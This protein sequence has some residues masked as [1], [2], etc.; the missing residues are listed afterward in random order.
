WGDTTRAPSGPDITDGA[1][2]TPADVARV[3][4]ACLAHDPMLR[5]ASARAVMAALPGGDPLQAALAAGET[6]SP[7]M[8]AAAG[9]RGDLGLPI[10]WTCLVATIAGVVLLAWMSASSSVIGLLQ[11]DKSPEVLA[12][13]ARGIVV[14]LGHEAPARD[15]AGLFLYDRAFLTSDTRRATPQHALAQMRPGPLLFVFRQSPA[16]LA[17]TH[18]AR[19]FVTPADVGRVDERDPATIV[20]GMATIVLDR[21]GM[22]SE[23]VA[24]PPRRLDAMP[25]AVAF[26]WSIAF[27]AAGLDIARFT[28]TAPRSTAPV[29]S[30][31]KAAWDGAY[32][33]PV[34]AR[35]HVEAAA[36]RGKPVWFAVQD[37]DA[38][39]PAGATVAA[40]ERFAIWAALA[41]CLAIAPPLILMIVR[42]LRAGRGD[43]RGAG[44]LA[45]FTFASIALA[46]L[47]RAD[48]VG[49][50]D[51][52][53]ALIVHILAQA[54]YFAGSIWFAYIAFEPYAR[55]RWPQSMI[56]WSR[57]VA[58]GLRDP[59]VGRDVLFG[60]LAGVVM[61]LVLHGSVLL[62][63]AF[64]PGSVSPVVQ[65]VSP[66]SSNRHALFFLL[67]SAHIAMA[68]GFGNLVG[69]LFLQ[70]L[71][72][73]RVLAV[74]LQFGLAYLFLSSTS[75]STTAGSLAFVVVTAVWMALAVRVGL[76]AAI[77]ATYVYFILYATPLSLDPGRWHFAGA[78]L[79][80][81]VLLALA[82]QAFRV[83]LA[84]RP[85]F[86]RAL[87]ELDGGESHPR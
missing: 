8:V 65:P 77:V 29:D 68:F 13:K 66:L 11:P 19:M 61:S 55:R 63:D 5:P 39:A 38:A 27:A 33:A 62:G 76:L 45:G 50:V 12:E 6:P 18:Y 24:V 82:V 67:S 48:H 60:V 71:V 16:P 36:M 37:P 53:T 34:D 43:R 7:A 35:V 26:D 14:A 52:E 83:S 59:M 32:A 30:D 56:S 20:P 23:F 46:L 70:G 58:G 44:R 9:E 57:L 54:A 4:A 47:G 41:F 40:P 72:R 21:H 49:A 73:T 78:A 1:R 42:N 25:Q 10:A 79:A 28:A 3:I 17:A 22:L 87:L 2:D 80:A 74:L 86:G 81:G 84:G 51:V 85:M 64:A 31:S 15:T 75:G 69:L